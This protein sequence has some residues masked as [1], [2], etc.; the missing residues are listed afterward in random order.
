MLHRTPLITASLQHDCA[1][2]L[3]APRNAKTGGPVT[4]PQLCDALEEAPPVVLT[5]H[6]A[7]LPPANNYQIIDFVHG[8]TKKNDAHQPASAAADLAPCQRPSHSEL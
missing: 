5:T 2:Y 3:D 8:I 6:H 1:H 4:P 7:A